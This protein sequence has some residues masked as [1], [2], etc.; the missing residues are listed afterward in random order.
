MS[1]WR[2]WC[3]LTAADVRGLATPV[4]AA[5]LRRPENLIAWLRALNYVKADVDAHIGDSQLRLRGHAPAVGERPSR[6]YLTLKREHDNR[7]ARRIRF[8]RSVEARIEECRFLIDRH[9]INP[10]GTFGG[11]VNNMARIA[12]LLE[13]DDL[14]N[15]L[16]LAR[17]A[18]VWA[19]EVLSADE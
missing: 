6:S 9:A 10:R 14:E 8:K 3:E 1:G 5:A 18:L 19:G 12:D 15:A 7:H 4:D 13:R 17:Q 16:R 11:L 2:E